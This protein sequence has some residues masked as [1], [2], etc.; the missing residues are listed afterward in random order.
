MEKETISTVDRYKGCLVGVAVGDALG[1]PL[2]FAPEKP[3]KPVKDM[4]PNPFNYWKKGEYT[5]DTMQTLLLTDSFIENQ[6]YNPD[7]FVRRLVEWFDNGNAKGLGNTTKIS[8]SLINEGIPWKDAGKRALTKGGV[9]ANGSL[10]R[11]APVGLFFR[12][13]HDSIKKVAAEISGITHAAEASIEVCQMAS[14]LVA[15][16]VNGESKNHAISSVKDKYR[17]AFNNAID[18]LP[19]QKKYPGGAYVTFAIALSCFMNTE[20]FEEAII[21]AVNRGGDTDTQASITGAFAGAYWEVTQIPERW[22]REI[23]PLSAAQIADKA[24]KLY[25]ATAN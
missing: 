23:N 2:E 6:S 10:M 21:K 7:D 11:T 13:N 17:T 18:S 19:D 25:A 16:L 3:D 12:D 1:Q 14:Q 15:N 4:L 24:Q 22:A 8:L 20:T 9:P 5:D